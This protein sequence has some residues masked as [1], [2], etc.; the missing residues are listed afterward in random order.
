MPA[1]VFQNLVHGGRHYN[2]GSEGLYT[3][4]QASSVHVERNTL[5]DVGD[6][7]LYFHC[8]NNNTFLNNVIAGVAM[9]TTAGSLKSCN[10]GGNPTWPDIVHGFTFER[11]IVYVGPSPRAQVATDTDYRNTTFRSNLYYNASQPLASLTWPNKTTWEAWQ[12]SGQDRGSMLADPL[13]TDVARQN[14]T[15]APSSPA[16]AL[17]WQPVDYSQI[18]P[19]AQR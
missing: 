2:Y 11:N 7:G 12:A 15:L 14:F 3:D 5:Y 9:Q 6:S 4:E 8:G 16:F 13:F 1:R 17:G 19:D 18:G 10:R